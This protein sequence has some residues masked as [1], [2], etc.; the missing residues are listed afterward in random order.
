MIELK[1]SSSEVRMIEFGDGTN[2]AFRLPVLGDPGVP[3]MVTST[4]ALIVDAFNNGT[5]SNER[6]MM[7]WSSFIDA[8]GASY[9]KAL[10]HLGAMDMEQVKHV[11]SHWFAES[12]KLTGIDPKV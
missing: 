11:M 3:M 1:H 5:P 2:V 9:P 10:Q 12:Q 7:L 6:V 8:L 4:V